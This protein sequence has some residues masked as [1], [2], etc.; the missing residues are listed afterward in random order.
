MIWKI[1]KVIDSDHVQ[2]DGMC[3]VSENGVIYYT[4]GVRK[5]RVNV[6]KTVCINVMD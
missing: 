2:N 3:L 1:Q 5:I 4:S 6:I